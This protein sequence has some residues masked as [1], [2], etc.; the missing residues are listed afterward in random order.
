[1]SALFLPGIRVSQMLGLD[2]MPWTTPA[3]WGVVGLVVGVVVS[4][5]LWGSDSPGWFSHI[6]YATIGLAVGAVLGIGWHVLYGVCRLG[7]W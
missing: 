4:R 6:P 5:R 2:S 1:M 3:S 7:M